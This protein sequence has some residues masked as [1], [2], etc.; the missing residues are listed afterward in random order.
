MQTRRFPDARA[1]NPADFPVNE[2]TTVTSNRFIL[3]WGTPRCYAYSLS[4]F[5]YYLSWLTFGPSAHL[6]IIGRVDLAAPTPVVPLNK[7]TEEQMWD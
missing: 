6:F 4:E 2:S 7:H 5:S 3:P 1:E